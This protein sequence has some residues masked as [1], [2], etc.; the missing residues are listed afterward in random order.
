M[1]VS[2][3]S[4]R[5]VLMV[6]HEAARRSMPPYYHRFAPKKF[7]RHQLFACLVLKTRLKLD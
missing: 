6:A 5:K 4:P 1:A 2:S 7:P 3:K